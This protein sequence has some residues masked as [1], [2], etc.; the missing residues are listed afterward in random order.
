MSKRNKV[1]IIV[2]S[3]V[4]I[5]LAVLLIPSVYR[6][7]DGGSVLYD[8]IL[9]DVRVHKTMAEDEVGNDGYIVGVTISIL[10]KEVYKKIEFVSKEDI[11]DY[12]FSF[13]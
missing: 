12:K 3:A 11:D 6:I 4:V 2:I 1:L 5:L 13:D 8:A 9:Y 7:K 10:D